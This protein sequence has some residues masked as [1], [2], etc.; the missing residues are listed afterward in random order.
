MREYDRTGNGQNGEAD[1]DLRSILCDMA[2]NWWIILLIAC[3]AAMITY[4]VL[5][6][7][8]R[9]QYTV[10]T[11][12]AVMGRGENANAASSLSA[13]YEMTQKF[14]AILENN[15]L[16]KKVMEELGGSSFPADMSAS[17][18]PES[19]LM[20]L[21]VTADSPETAFRVLRSVLK[22]YTTISDYIIPNLVLETLQQP[23]GFR[24]S[25]EPDSDGKV[26]CNGISGGRAWYGGAGGLLF[27]SAGYRQK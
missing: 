25:V 26:R 2:K 16:K 11:T 7:V 27:L 24:Q 10:K 4:T 12:F 23:Q 15:I 18:V 13:T 21:S 6:A 19:N 1:W 17:I 20:E 14:Q 9:D 8:H 22:N 3:S 5:T